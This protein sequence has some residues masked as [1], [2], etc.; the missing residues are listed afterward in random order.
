MEKYLQVFTTLDKKDA[1]DQMARE[2][3]EKRM[4]ACAQV[5]GP[6]NSTYW[7]QGKVEVSEEWLCLMKT[8]QDLYKG[9]EETI[10][11]IHSY[12]VPEIIAVPIVEGHADYLNWLEKVVNG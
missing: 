9:L 3:V 5:I 10:K 7:W 4:A 11:T 2:V 1:A 8:T 6:I 12:D